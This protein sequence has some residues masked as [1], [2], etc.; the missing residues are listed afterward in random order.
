MSY[1]KISA[2][3]FLAF[4][5]FFYFK[6]SYSFRALEGSQRA[7]DLVR[8]MNA[9]CEKKK[10]KGKNEQKELIEQNF[11]PGDTTGGHTHCVTN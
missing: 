7:G 6:V 9:L 3:S 10:E 11:T 1:Y 4:F 5:F 8:G 2:I